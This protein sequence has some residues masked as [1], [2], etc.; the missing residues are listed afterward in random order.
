MQKFVTKELFP[1]W[2]A[3]PKNEDLECFFFFLVAINNQ[4]IDKLRCF[5]QRKKF[6]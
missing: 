6:G 2:R 4:S 1:L 3:I 5:K